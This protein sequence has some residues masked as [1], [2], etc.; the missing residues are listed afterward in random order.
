MMERVAVARRCTGDTESM[1]RRTPRL[2]A[3]VCIA[4]LSAAAGCHSEFEGGG[5]LRARRVALQRE[6]ASLREAVA[7]LERG[8]PLLPLEDVVV[9]I[10]DAMLRDLIVAQL[11]FEI[12]AK[13]FKATL[14]G[15]EVLFRGSPLVTLR[16]SG[17]PQN[18]S[19]LAAAV[20]VTGALDDV[21]VD[22][23]TGTLRARISVDHLNIEQVAGL[24]SLLSGATL[25]ELARALRLQLADQLPEIQIP[26]KVQ[27]G[28]E[29]PTVD[30]GPV[31]IA[32]ATMPL[33]V[34]VSRVF[35][36]QGRLWISVRVRPGDLVKT[37]SEPSPAKA[38]S[39]GRA[40]EGKR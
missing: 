16:G 19:A 26:V 38:P 11:P 17:S 20:T 22:P 18:R 3:S 23:A 12:E 34:G 35:A 32:G 33:E 14:T 39:A 10:D 13:G 6:V 36:G 27:Q 31:R 15:A 25:D 21:K 40:P 7:R 37:A 2:C 24:E 29:L 4:L 1:P 9:A 5:A 30:S 8:E 28:I